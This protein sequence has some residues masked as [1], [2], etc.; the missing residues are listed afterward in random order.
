MARIL[1]DSGELAQTTL[2]CGNDSL[3][4]RGIRAMAQVINT[5]IMSLTAQRHLMIS[6]RTQNEAMERL[7]SGLRINTAADDAAGLAIADRMTAQ[8]RGMNMAIR[9]S[10]DAV[11]VVQTS[12]GAMQETT[13]MLQRMRELAIQ[14][15]NGSNSEA[16]RAQLQD[17]VNQLKGEMTRIAQTTNFN[18]INLLDDS[19]RDRRF[20]IGASAVEDLEVSIS[21]VAADELERHSLNGVAGTTGGVAAS[22]G[23]GAGTAR[24]NGATSGGNSIAQQTLTIAGH[25]GEA[26]ISQGTI[27]ANSTAEEI[28]GWV[29]NRTVETGVSARASTEA[30]LRMDTLGS[31]LTSTGALSF[32]LSAENKISRANS[33]GASIAI[34]GFVTSTGDMT[35]VAD[36]V[37]NAAGTTGITA[38]LTEDRKTIMLVQDEGKDID[39][40]RVQFSSASSGTDILRVQG[41]DIEQ[42]SASTGAVATG[43]WT[44]GGVVVLSETGG[45]TS[46]AVAG[47]VEF[48]ST[49]A[50]TVESNVGASAG[51][52]APSLASAGAASEV[53]RV[54]DVDISTIA[55]AIDAIKI[56]DQALAFV[57]DQRAYLGA[58]QNRLESTINNLTNVSENTSS[59]RSRI[60]DADFAA[61]SA[62]LS[63]AQVLQQAGNAML[64]QANASG[65]QVLQLLQG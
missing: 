15:A 9:N 48:E 41:T 3:T 44:A 11:S 40:K 42:I 12:D 27:V 56:V 6:Q 23:S 21:G 33:V 22:S 47:R 13:N 2:L 63:K 58:V 38:T 64:A 30:F 36:A 7:S 25:R 5:N 26:K 35:D 24:A 28:A 43:F 34:T 10:N 8:I 39:I 51:G 18:G 29:N 54:S 59:A 4:A 53:A 37:N 49:R 16:N 60:R 52:I 45:N 19:F 1:L 55:G 17:E 57:D 14:A 31:V 50:F 46:V 32:T 62:K 65:Q 61:E 20:H